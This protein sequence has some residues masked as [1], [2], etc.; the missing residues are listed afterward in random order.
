MHWGLLSVVLKCENVHFCACVRAC[1]RAQRAGGY[2]EVGCLMGGVELLLAVEE[3][4]DGGV[5]L[6]A[7][8]EEVE[9][10]DEDVAQ[11]RAAELLDEGACCCSGAACVAWLAVSSEY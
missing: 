3:R 9:L 7:A 2:A 11:E 8:L 6:V 10:E 1:V 5:E 4:V